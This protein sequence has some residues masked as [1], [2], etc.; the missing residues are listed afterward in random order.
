MAVD[1]PSP[2]LAPSQARGQTSSQATKAPAS[3]H[4]LPTVSASAALSQLTAAN[5]ASGVPTG[6][7]GLDAFLVGGG[8]EAPLSSATA[9]AVGGGFER[10]KVFE[11]WGPSGAGKTGIALQ[12]AV[13]AL[14]RGEHVV[15]I[16]ASKPLPGPRL[17]AALS[18]TPP[19]DTTNTSPY[20]LNNFHHTTTPTLSHLLALLLYPP[21][22]FPP[23]HTSLLIIDGLPTLLDLDYPRTFPSSAKT[24]AQRWASSRRYAVLGTLSSALAKL[25]I[26]HDL[27]IVVTT[28]CATRGRGEAGLGSVLVPG[29]G[30]K[31]WEAGVAGRMVVF[32]DFERNGDGGEGLWVGVQKVRGKRVVGIGGEGEGAVGKVFAFERVAEAERGVALREPLV[33]AAGTGNGEVAVPDAA[34]LP[35]RSSVGAVASVSPVKEAR[36]RKRVFEEIADSEGEDEFGWSGNDDEEAMGVHEDLIAGEQAATQ[37]SGAS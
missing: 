29:L 12:T 8:N 11:V 21:D 24:D 33:A 35:K 36:S 34:V 25:A 19:Q 32:R 31:E 6:L 14:H 26:V 9:T 13:L 18:A 15:W 23:P 28:G 27:A 3:S 5:R 30:G 37:A 10:G 20:P 22:T 16:D 1:A 7:T 2:H 17:Q 4:R